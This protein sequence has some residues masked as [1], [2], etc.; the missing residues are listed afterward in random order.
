MPLG[1]IYVVTNDKI[2][3]WLFSKH[4]LTA[5]GGDVTSGEFGWGRVQD[6]SREKRKS[7]HEWIVHFVGETDRTDQQI[8]CE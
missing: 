8:D 5:G 6:S 1:L 7:C 4:L 3:F 2:S